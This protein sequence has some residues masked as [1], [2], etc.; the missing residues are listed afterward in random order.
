MSNRWKCWVILVGGLV[1]AHLGANPQD[2]SI[3]VAFPAQDQKEDFSK[4]SLDELLPFLDDDLYLPRQ[5]AIAELKKR[6]PNLKKPDLAKVAVFYF[7]IGQPFEIHRVF[8]KYL[9]D[10]GKSPKAKAALNMV[11][12]LQESAINE[13][14]ITFHFGVYEGAVSSDAEKMQ[15]FLDLR[16]KWAAYRGHLQVGD[17]K[18]ALVRLGEIKKFLG[19]L[20]N[21]QFSYLNLTKDGMAVM[22]EAVLKTVE[23]AG[24]LANEAKL[25]IEGKGK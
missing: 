24:I 3:S 21:L 14:P 4:K 9:I 7:N 23:T 2:E 17:A 19:G 22:K 1:C 5:K 13:T 12:I 11:W 18:G 15:I 25:E 10:L 20:S 16:M 8:Q 6:L